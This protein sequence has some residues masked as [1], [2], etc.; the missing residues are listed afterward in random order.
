MRL[1]ETDINFGRN[2]GVE[3]RVIEV[4]IHPKHQS[5]TTHYNVGIAVAGLIPMFLLDFKKRH[6]A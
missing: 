1:G 2:F 6:S 5:G 3:R 4:H